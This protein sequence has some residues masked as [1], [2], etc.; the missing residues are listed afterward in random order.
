M[1]CSTA[2]RGSPAV[3]DIATLVTTLTVLRRSRGVQ[4]AVYHIRLLSIQTSVARLAQYRPFERDGLDLRAALVDLV[5]A[6]ALEADGELPSLAACQD[7]CK[8]LW[9]IHV[10]ID[11][12][13]SILDGLVDAGRMTRS[14][15]RFALAQPEEAQ[16]AER[17]RAS[18]AIERRAFEDWEVALRSLN[19]GLTADD[20]A[21]LRADLD[22][23]LQRLITR[24]GVESALIL[25]PEVPRAQQ[26]FAEIEQEGLGFLP[27]RQG[28]VDAIREQAL[29]L[30][31]RQPTEAQ[32][33]LLATLLNTAYFLTILSLDPSAGALVQQLTTGQR[34]Y[35]DTNFV[36][37]I[38]D[39]QGPTHYLSSKRLLELTQQLG[40]VTAVTP[41]TV[42]ELKESLER[43]RDFLMKQPI[44]PAE[45][46]ELA[47]SATT[48]EN[49]VTAY[50][51]RLR[52][53]P[54]A[55]KD[56][57]EFYA[58]IEDHLADH[59]ITVMDEGC[60]AVDRD[61]RGINDELSALERALGTHDRH[62]E[63]KLHDVKHRLLIRRLRA[64][65][66]RFSNAGYWFLTCDSLLP[67]YDQ[68]A[69]AHTE[70]E[71]PFC[72]SSSA[73]FQV[74]R[75]FTPRTEDFDQTLAD[76][77]ASPYIRYRGR[78]SYQTVEQV[79]ARID[80]YK[81]RTPELAAKVLL[82][83]A[84]MRDVG[85]T[86]DEERRLQLIDNAIIRAAA[87]RERELA[88]AKERE[89]REREARRAAQARE[90]ALSQELEAERIRREE[91]Q[92]RA[93]AE[94][95]R[96]LRTQAEQSATEIERLKAEHDR[97][98]AQLQRS[99]EKQA[100]QLS[101]LYQVLERKRRHRLL[102]LSAMIV[103]AAGAG[104]VA[105][106][107]RHTVTGAWP[108]TLV[109][110]AALALSAGALVPH[111]GHKRVWAA[112]AA[113]GIVLGIVLAVH[114][115]VADSGSKP[116]PGTAPGKTP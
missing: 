95:A 43:A 81:G 108:I 61:E 14:N 63:V 12:L 80:L 100:E 28:R 33:T 90:Q 22:A 92:E 41:W 20:V 18:S 105:A 66:R 23:W 21:T 5:V 45:L 24:H 9:G 11:E 49:F 83:T 1:G 32:R 37:R 75:S 56:F 78:I 112:I 94:R 114:E 98:L 109:I 86:R 50:W 103:I 34:I 39:L 76:L 19:A 16:L 27:R 72:A 59:G 53:H 102:W 104:A 6:A 36:Y 8:A 13:R 52:E 54:V 55:P 101:L 97:A 38:L 96:L 99:L 77:L 17:L 64:G 15:G 7:H 107:A 29:Y 84:L 87:E 35:L 25:Y 3:G 40:Y 70:G 110:V 62:E 79:V 30:F 2:N 106:I 85:A 89:A 116:A 48:D 111:V 71:L 26:L 68:M 82:D 51:V 46:A 73:W 93:D 57:Y 47:A 88:E 10:E 58:Q 115:L 91:E 67:R 65:P 69:A 113:F 42:R 44:P 31:V 4:G 74:M 60:R